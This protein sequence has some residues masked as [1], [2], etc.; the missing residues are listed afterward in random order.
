MEGLLCS[1]TSD[2]LGTYADTAPKIFQNLL[3][4]PSSDSM[5]FADAAPTIL[6]GLLL[7]PSTDA[8]GS[9][10]DTW[11]FDLQNL[12]NPLSF[13]ATDVLGSYADQSPIILQGLLLNPTSDAMTF[14]DQSNAILAYLVT[15]SDTLN[16]WADL[17]SGGTHGVGELDFSAIDTLNLW[18]DSLKGFLTYSFSSTDSMNNWADS[19]SA[20][21]AFILI[22]DPINVGGMM[23]MGLGGPNI[24]GVM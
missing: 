13:S 10:T 17:L 18:S 4:N 1:P 5:T 14:A 12:L 21:G 3:V 9:Y 23:K 15:P 22:Y 6:E 11:N 20:T 24:G 16:S 8:L 19:F 2:S 7:Q